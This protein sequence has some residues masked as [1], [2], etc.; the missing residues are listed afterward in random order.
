VIQQVTEGLI[1]VS[2]VN[3]HEMLADILTKALVR[4]TFER[5]RHSILGM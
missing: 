4:A 2:Y 1:E 5:L 3:T